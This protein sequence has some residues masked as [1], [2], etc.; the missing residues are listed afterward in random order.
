MSFAYPFG[1]FSPT[2]R[3]IVEDAGFSSAVAVKYA[4]SSTND[5]PFA[6]SRLIVSADTS[7]MGF[8]ALL[9]TQ[10]PW[11]T[12]MAERARARVWQVARRLQYTISRERNG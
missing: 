11:Q 3:R 10:T 7:L 2:V 1:Y 12:R 8:A 9:T 5:D 4:L 6:L